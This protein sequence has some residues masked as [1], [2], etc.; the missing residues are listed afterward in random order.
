M[1]LQSLRYFLALFEKRHFGRAAKQC[2]IAQPSM[3]KAIKRL[4]QQIGGRLFVRGP[5]ITPTPLALTLKPHVEQ[6]LWAVRRT[7]KA[8]DHM[9]RTK[10]GRA[11]KGL[12]PDLASGGTSEPA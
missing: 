3:T 8:L 10:P 6:I 11:T 7:E 12:H 1:E 9:L 2:R 4:E 5:I